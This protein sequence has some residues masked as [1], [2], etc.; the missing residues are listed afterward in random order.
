MFE[1]I[2]GG[3]S[4]SFVLLVATNDLRFPALTHV[5]VGFFFFQEPEDG[6]ETLFH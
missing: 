4:E 3:V 1:P 5:F 6:D 2:D